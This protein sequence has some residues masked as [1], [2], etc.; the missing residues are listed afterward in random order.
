MEKGDRILLLILAAL[1][2]MALPVTALANSAEPPG[3]VILALN[4][5]EDMTLTLELET[6]T[7]VLSDQNRI[8]WESHYRFYYYLDMEDLAVAVIRVESGGQSFTCTLPEG[9]DDGY[10]NVL[11]LDF[12]E[13]SLTLGEPAWRQPLLIGLRLSLTLLIEAVVLW[14]FGFRAKR[15]WITFLI[16]NL[17]T[18]GLLNISIA[19]GSLS[20]GYW[21]VFYYLAEILIFIVETTAFP[22][23]TKE[24]KAVRRV[25]AVL[26][27]NA[28][29]LLL[30]GWLIA[31]L[32]V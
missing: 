9:V 28:A 12:E 26:A 24:K 1:L 2:V 4:A 23:V 5:P 21:V 30:G 29:S 3:M 15:S 20:G 18:Q 8:Q 22:L 31:N 32:P 10:N 17:V 7:P 19:G 13:R 27:A 16:I 14:L 6:G 11:T 25:L